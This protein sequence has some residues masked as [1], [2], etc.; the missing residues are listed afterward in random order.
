MPA[1]ARLDAAAALHSAQEAGKTK[2]IIDSYA[3]ADAAALRGLA[4]D[5]RG[6]TGRFVAVVGGATDGRPT[7]LVAASRDLA[8]EGFD[9]GAIVREA[10]PIFGGG[11]GGR[12]DLAQAGGQDPDRLDD[13]CARPAAW[14]SRRSRASRRPDRRAAVMAAV[15]QLWGRVAGRVRSA[16]RGGSAPA[17]AALDIGRSSRRRWC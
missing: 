5:L 1:A 14:R 13:A 15:G 3:D 11:G 8:A 12:A 4:D 16:A 2:V 9:S 7:L 17:I 10:A 6:M